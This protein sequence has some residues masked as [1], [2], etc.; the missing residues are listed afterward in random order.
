MQKISSFAIQL[1]N[2]NAA[3]LL[4]S[5]H[6]LLILEGLPGGGTPQVADAQVRALV[7]QGRNVVGY[8][9]AGVTD[10]FRPYWNSNW[11]IVPPGTDQK[12]W[13]RQPLS[14]DP[15][16]PDWL[17]NRP[18]NEFGR[19]VDFTDA[20]WQSI[21]IDYAVDLVR[22]GY[23][24][25][26]IDDTLS[27]FTLARAG[28]GTADALATEMMRFVVRIDDAI[29]AVNPNAVTIVNGSPYIVTDV[30]GGIT[31]AASQAY[32]GAVDA[33]LLENLYNQPAAYQQAR[34][35]IQP[36]VQLLATEATAGGLGSTSFIRSALEMG[37]TPY[38]HDADYA[39]LHDP[40]NAGTD[41]PDTLLGGTGPNR[42]DG[43]GS[44]DVIN[45]L[46]GDDALRG[47]AGDDVLDGGTGIDTLIG[48]EGQDTYVVDALGDVVQEL[49]GQG[50]DTVYVTID[51][52]VAP[53]NVDIIRLTGTAFIVTG[54]AGSE[55]I[56]A[57]PVTG[58]AINA[59][60]GNDTLWGSALQ[61]YFTGGAGDDIFRGGGGPDFMLGGTG[62]DQFIV[63]NIGTS[64]TENAGEGTDT[65]WLTVNFWTA[66]AN[67]EIIRLAG[68]AFYVTGSDGS[69]QIVGNPIFGAAINGGGGDDTLWGSGLDE[70]FVGGA[71]DDII[72]GGGGKDSM[73]GGLGNDQFI[74]QSNDTVI[75]E[76]AG[77]GYDT[78][79]YTVSGMTMTA[80]VERANLSGAA[81]AVAGN[82]QDNL[83]VGNTTLGN[84]FL[85]G[86]EGSDT[87]FGGAFADLFRGDAGNDFLYSGGGA[88]R[89]V[90]SA[91]GFGYDS[92]NGFAQG[93]AK[94]DFRGSGIGFANV[95]LRS[96]GGNTQVEVFGDAILVFG[97]SSLTAADFLF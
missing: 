95:F 97:V 21:V 4:A 46:Q 53:A 89:F 17:K 47:S 66:P 18:I 85:V 65:A 68:S 11:T 40:I 75:T 82:A 5:P 43:G 26:F 7:Q 54:S 88:D 58:G 8:V 96:A 30:N 37:I 90:Y 51:G 14:S 44:S 87:I 45:G 74:V 55:Q 94:L 15:T 19:A 67:L 48:G 60:E 49:A 69:E 50:V 24:G 39:G 76:F 10:S 13:D 9:N 81:N 63:E 38:V 86:G 12:E 29:R 56:V 91:T 79:W 42:I 6:D 28:Y 83:I 23:T 35:F 77:E 64:I 22:R 2:A 20:R 41:G 25:V 1:G 93:A 59:A 57:N 33:V 92:I 62:D 84:A 71:G 16:I 80:N 32:L 3:Q 72:R 73:T 70:T 61:E 27:Y 34:S 36:S 78:A 52:W 31:T